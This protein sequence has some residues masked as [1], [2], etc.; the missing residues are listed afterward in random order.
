MTTA[1][2]TF[3]YNESVN[4]PIWI[5][6]YGRNFGEENLFIAD[7]GSNDGS[8]D[9]IGR[10]NLLK[11]PRNEFDEFNKTD[12][13]GG[14]HRS[15]LNFY[16]TVIVTDCDELLTADPHRFPTLRDYVDNTDFEY[17]NAIGLEIIHVLNQDDPIDLSKPI[18]SQR[19]F[20]RFHSASCKNL[21]ARRPI[22]WLTGFHSA[23]HPP[24]F[25]GALY[26][27]HTRV[28]DFYISLAR[29]KINRETLWSA[30]SLEQNLGAHHRYD[31]ATFVHQN[32]LVPLDMIAR[33]EVAEF[34]FDW[35]LGR[36]TAE[37]K[38]HNGYF[39]IPMEIQKLVRI[40]E[41]F[42]GAL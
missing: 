25:D 3:S 2:I 20:C 38:E 7:R 30:R 23:D 35:E 11:L 39:Y 16:D 24:R 1:V 8:I 14:L 34:E 31:Q 28:M 13:V 18:L 32:F 29:Q 22:K 19:S 17:M 15:L 36:I 10:C 5:A 12:F 40:P 21:I 26:M 4:L 42:A 41:R 37:T 6:H 33:G 9:N 27:F